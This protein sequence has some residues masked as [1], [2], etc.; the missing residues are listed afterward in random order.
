MQG[1]W[2][3]HTCAD[4]SRQLH[5]AGWVRNCPDGRVEAVF[6][7]DGPTVANMVAWCHHGPERATV[8]DVAEKDEPPE[9][10]TNFRVVGGD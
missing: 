9:G 8:T 2:F 10:L 1:V 5:L 4:R 3:R 6:E 7:G